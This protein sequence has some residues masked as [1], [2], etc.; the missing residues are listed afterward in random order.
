MLNTNQKLWVILFALLVL[1]TPWVAAQQSTATLAGTISDETGAVLPGVEITVR[2]VENGSTRTAITDDRGEYRVTNLAPGEYELRAQLPGFQTAVRSGIGLNVGR[3]VSLNVSLSVGSVSE[4]VIVTGDAPLVDTLTSTVRELVD[5][6]KIRDLPL[7][8]RSFE[9]LALL[10]AGV[11]AHR[12]HT[13]PNASASTASGFRFSVGGARPTANSFVLDGTNINDAQGATPG[14][15]SGVNLGVEAIREFEILTN[16][17][18]ATFGRSAGAIINVVTKSGTNQL[19]GSV[20][21]FHRND[22]LDA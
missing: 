10:Q 18:D 20:F 9:Q 1:T 11:V 21:Y 19:H 6:R 17:F 15:A 12:G 7:N 3:S 4:E 13:N 22:N 16:S 5:D 8:G 14:S 2:N